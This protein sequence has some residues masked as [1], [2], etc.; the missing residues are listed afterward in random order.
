MSA[1]GRPAL[2]G[3][4]RLRLSILPHKAILQLGVHMPRLNP[5]YFLWSDCAKSRQIRRGT[6]GEDLPPTLADSVGAQ[7]VGEL[8]PY[9]DGPMRFDT[10][11][12]SLE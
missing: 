4:T 1:E 9:Q 3:E 12:S 5:T 8:G 6:K 7:A 2:L 11:L 10:D